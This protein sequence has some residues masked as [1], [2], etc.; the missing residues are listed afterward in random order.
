LNDPGASDPRDLFEGA[1]GYVIALLDPAPKPA[2][3][4]QAKTYDPR[5]QQAADEFLGTQARI[6]REVVLP[7]LRLGRP[8]KGKG[9]RR[10]GNLLRDRWIA[11]VV[12]D[13][14]QR[15]GLKPYR[16]QYPANKHTYNGCSVV[17]EVLNELKID[18]G[19]KTVREIYGK[20]RRA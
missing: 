12:A 5:A 11:A 3:P 20:H 19:E 10:D 8:P 15:H 14:C 18:L 17:A 1:V 16:N 13:I 6:V 9:Q 7:A 2:D 4:D